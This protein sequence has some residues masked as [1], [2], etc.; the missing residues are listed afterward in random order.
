MGA[1]IWAD[2]EGR[3]TTAALSDNSI[4][5]A[6][7]EPLSA[8]ADKLGVA[9]LSS[10][11]DQSQLMAE[12]ADMLPEGAPGADAVWF[13][14]GQVLRSVAAIRSHLQAEPGALKFTPSNSQRHWPQQ[15]VAELTHCQE[16]ME[17]AVAS[18]KKVRLLIVP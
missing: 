10:F 16:V 18:G 15:L 6:L 12:Y 11:H 8:I 17:A 14:P 2:T 4:M 5:L 7:D 9:R 3:A 1:T 13:E